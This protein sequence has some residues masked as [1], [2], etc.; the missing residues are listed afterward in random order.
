[1]LITAFNICV[2]AIREKCF[3]LFPL[4]ELYEGPGR[5]LDLV[6]VLP[7]R[8]L[9]PRPLPVVAPLDGERRVLPAQ[10]GGLAQEGGDRDGRVVVGVGVHLADADGAVGQRRRE[11]G[12]LDD[13]VGPRRRRLELGRHS[14][15]GVLIGLNLTDAPDCGGLF[16]RDVVER[17]ARVGD[18]ASVLELVVAR[19]SEGNGGG[20]HESVRIRR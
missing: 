9:G 2:N 18:R 14:L 4:T 20:E 11:V 5:D 8:P 12:R 17:L 19:E 10:L 6:E 16:D 13:E 3:T 7:V 1:M 15:C